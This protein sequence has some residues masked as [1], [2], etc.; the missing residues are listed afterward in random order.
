MSHRI[1]VD[2]GVDIRQVVKFENQ[3]KFAP[4]P[5]YGG[6]TVYMYMDDPGVYYDVHGN[7]LPEGIAKMAGFSI[8]KLAKARK[9]KEAMAQ[10]EKR[11]AQ[12]LAL[13]QDEEIVIREAG[14]WKIL[15]LPMDRAKIVDKDTG[16]MVTPVPLSRSDADA[17]LNHLVGSADTAADAVAEDVV[18]DTSH[19]LSTSKQKEHAHGRSSS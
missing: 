19:V 1:D 5:R 13:E 10:F 17:L 7:K 2:R 14:D 8:D 9:K 11:I 4:D 6:L 18:I 16:E 15:A 3:H 12:E